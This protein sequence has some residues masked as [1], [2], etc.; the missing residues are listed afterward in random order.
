MDPFQIEFHYFEQNKDP[1][2]HISE[3]PDFGNIGYYSSGDRFS[4]SCAPRKMMHN[5]IDE[6]FWG[7]T[8]KNRPLFQFKGPRFLETPDLWVRCSR[9]FFFF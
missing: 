5:R 1:E 4:E 7:H 6:I 8:F 2:I 3:L 9:L